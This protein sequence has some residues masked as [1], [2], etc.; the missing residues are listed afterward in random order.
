MGTVER[1]PA[2]FMG[3][4]MCALILGAV[5]VPVLQALPTA[6][7]TYATIINMLM[8]ILP[9]VLVVVLIIVVMYV[10]IDKRSS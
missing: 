5:V 3:V 10:V 7:G 6:T 8:G 4:L 9:V 2:L 1:L